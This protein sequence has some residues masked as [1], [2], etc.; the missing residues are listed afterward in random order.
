[1][2]III[3]SD[4]QYQDFNDKFKTWRYEFTKRDASIILTNHMV[5]VDATGDIHD[6][7]ANEQI[8]RHCMTRVILKIT[9]ITQM[10][11]ILFVRKTSLECKFI[12]ASNKHI[13]QFKQAFSTRGKFN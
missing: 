3:D 5:R 10:F 11:H 6:E 4:Q 1:M 2:C 7:N 9:L 13:K 8:Q 12:C